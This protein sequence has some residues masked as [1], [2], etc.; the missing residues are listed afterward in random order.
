[1]VEAH[2]SA[3]QEDSGQAE[4]KDVEVYDLNQ[5]RKESLGTFPV[6]SVFDEE[7]L[8]AR[9]ALLVRELRAHLSAGST[10]TGGGGLTISFFAL[11][12]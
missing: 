5:W 4:L 2:S 7:V 12:I 11:H 1:M 3:K 6:S 9:D 8:A 10:T